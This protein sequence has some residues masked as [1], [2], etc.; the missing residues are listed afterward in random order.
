MEGIKGKEKHD[1]SKHGENVRDQRDKKIKKV[2]R[3]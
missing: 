2:G 3:L 1:S